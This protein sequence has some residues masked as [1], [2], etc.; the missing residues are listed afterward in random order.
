[1]AEH[2]DF[3]TRLE[4]AYAQ[5][6]AAAPIDI[7]AQELAATLAVG[8]RGTFE[9]RH[10]N[11]Q[12]RRGVGLVAAVALLL[13]AIVVAGA[14]IGARRSS[15]R[16]IFEIVGTMAATADMRW[17]ATTPM[18][19]GL[20]D[21]RVLIA[22]GGDGLSGRN[23]IPAQLFDPDS[24]ESSLITTDSPSGEGA[25]IE[26]QDGRVLLIGYDRNSTSSVAFLLDPAQMTSRSLP[27]PGFPNAPPFGVSP[28][29]AG[30]PD[31][32]VVVSGGLADVYEPTVL[33]S[34]MLFDPVTETFVPTGAMHD[35]RRWHSMV[36]MS[37]GRVLVVGGEGRDSTEVYDPAS[38]TFTDGPTMSSVKGP[39]LAIAIPDGRVVV[40]PRF[41]RGTQVNL[42]AVL[43]PDESIPESPV[44]IY[45]PGTG[46]FSAATPAPGN[47]TAA[48]LLRDGT[49]LMI[50]Q[51]PTLLPGRV[52]S[53]WESWAAIYDVRAES[54]TPTAAP[55]G[56]FG[57]V[58]VLADGRVLNAGGWPAGDPFLS[59]EPGSAIEIFD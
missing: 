10:W 37:D 42:G 5:L 6:V 39:T 19:L 18:V 29:M 53:D 1:M 54:V 46:T 23:V 4:D 7:D 57:G 36:A 38:G 14:L 47:I 34:A 9:G 58:A 26:L 27:Q 48:A 24:H 17:N 12:A 59:E 44:D 3:E 32:R 8:T 21:G 30:L 56:R 15:Y 51:R 49:I 31:G 16:G 52:F 25:A 50:G 2:R 33:A 55:A 13:L 11:T 45:D 20:R 41:L 22:G 35:T 43:S 28:S 40:M